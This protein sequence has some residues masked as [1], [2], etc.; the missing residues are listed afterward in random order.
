M[1]LSYATVAAALVAT[2]AASNSTAV[3]VTDVVT[4]YTTV[5]P[6]ATQLTFNGVTYTATKSQTITITNCPCT[7][8]KL[9]TVAP[10]STVATSK[11]P[12][13]VNSTVPAVTVSASKTA[14][15][16]TSAAV[17]A[18]AASFTGAANRAVVGSAAGL[19]GLLGLAA[20]IL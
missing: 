15:G 12:V 20:Y 1:Q 17:T 14:V 9:A 4:A 16:T 5:C 3:W 10:V 13:Y 2:V 6:A 8:S 7:V 11:A 19:A 18:P